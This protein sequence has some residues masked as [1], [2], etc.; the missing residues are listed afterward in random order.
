M[1]YLRVDV[2]VGHPEFGRLVSCECRR[3]EVEARRFARLMAL[4][5][6]GPELQAKSFANFR[7]IHRER[8]DDRP[9]SNRAAVEVARAFAEE[10]WGWLVLAGGNGCGKTHLAAGIANHCLER[11]ETVFFASVP[12]LLDHLRAT[13]APD[14]PARFDEL[15]ERVR[16]VP[17]L[18]L[19]DLGA[20]QGTEWAWEK[21]YQVLV[22]RR[23][24][25]LPLVVT[26]N[27]DVTHSSFPDRRIG[28]RLCESGWARRVLITAPDFRR[29]ECG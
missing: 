29:G 11:G 28:S 13:F 12:D 20:Q 8:K 7:L 9:E 15:F 6:L 22:H 27:L 14:A 17:L 3:A 24:W 16:E 21:L 4:S 1:G 25:H 19:D 2:P 26:T 18:I 10:P 23:R 5:G